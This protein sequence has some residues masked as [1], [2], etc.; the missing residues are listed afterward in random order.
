MKSKEI[1]KVVKDYLEAPEYVFFKYKEL[2][3]VIESEEPNLTEEKLREG[4]SKCKFK[5]PD[6]VAL[7]C[8][9]FP[10]LHFDIL[11]RTLGGIIGMM[12]KGLVWF[13]LFSS[14]LLIVGMI[15]DWK[16]DVK[17][18]AVFLINILTMSYVFRIYTKRYN[19]IEFIYHV[20]HIQGKI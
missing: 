5:A 2:I 6:V 8:L 7:Q 1:D 3:D 13:V 10:P 9:V 4:I 17:E 19:T 12:Y 11:D 18:I 20:L 15:R 16:L 14:I